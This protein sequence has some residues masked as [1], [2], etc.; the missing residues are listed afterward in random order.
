M[1]LIA[2]AF[3]RRQEPKML[4]HDTVYLIDKE[5]RNS[6]E[7]C[8]LLMSV[9]QNNGRDFKQGEKKLDCNTKSE[10]SW[11]VKDPYSLPLNP[12]KLTS[13]MMTAW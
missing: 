11:D 4:S 6:A 10:K 13:K 12:Q 3:V 9:L 2:Q 7:F 8:S 5:Q 1:S